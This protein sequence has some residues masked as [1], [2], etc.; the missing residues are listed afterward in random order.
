MTYTDVLAYIDSYWD[1]ITRA[2]PDE[3]GTLIG[4]PRPYLL[5]SDDERPDGGK[6]FQE[7]YYWDSFF[8]S[9]GVVGTPRAALA[10]DMA[11]N[12]AY[13]FNRFGVIPNGSRY[14]FLSRSQPPLFTQQMRLVY[15][16]GLADKAWLADMVDVAIRE[17]ETVWLGRQQPHHRVTTTPYDSFG[18]SRYF[19]INYLDM[20]ASCES[21]WDHSTRCD[22]RWLVHLP[23]DLNALL[24]LR[25]GDIAWVL[26][27]IGREAD[28]QTW[29]ARA[30]T[31]RA[32]IQRLMWDEEAGFFF[33][34][35]MQHS[36][37]NPHVSLAGFFPLWAGLA[38]PEQAAAL[39]E[40]W[41]PQFEF[42]GGLVTTLKEQPGRQWAYPNGWA[43]LQW[44]VVAGLQRYGYIDDARRIMRAWCD[45]VAAVFA[46]TDRFG[47][48]L[49]EKYNVVEPNML[50]GVSEGLYGQVKG[51]GWTNGVFVDFAR[52]LG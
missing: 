31:R 1:R 42:P 44:I 38:A 36:E 4:L 7:M 21:G 22:D 3:R 9:L 2:N 18:L 5:P 35:D 48:A 49:W 45:Q 43:P 25:E 11:D 32:A 39:V 8:M 19:D 28:A 23:V 46:R 30:E 13:L 47:G 41:L 14:Y 29:D 27:E 24:Y 51:F 10:R 37:R 34:Y 17:Q 16:H 33:D 26:R 20:L 40:T 15:E 50:G 6:M 12:M 52:R